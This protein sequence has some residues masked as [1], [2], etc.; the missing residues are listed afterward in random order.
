MAE[1]SGEGFIHK[2]YPDLQ[3]STSVAGAIRHE[4][5][6]IGVKI[7]NSPDKRLEIFL[8]TME[9]VFINDPN[10]PSSE[11]AEKTALRR[12]EI[13][14]KTFLY[15]AVL[16]DRD[17]VPD[18]YFVLQIK[19]AKERGQ[20]GDLELNGIGNVGDV[21]K[22]KRR[23]VGVVIYNDQKKSLDMWV[24]YLASPDSQYP[25]WFK[26]YTLQ[27]VLK[28]GT[29]DKSK[30]EFS[31]R[32]KETTTIFPDL[33]REALAYV[34]DSLSQYY[35]KDK[36]PESE[37]L[38]RVLKSANFGK[39]YTFS[40]ERTTPV[41][42]ENKK[43]TEGE[44]VKFDKGSD[45][46]ALYESLQGYGTGWCTAGEET[47]RSQLQNGDFYV[48]YTKDENGRN[49]IPRIAVRMESGQVAEVR[50]INDHQNLEE[51]MLDIARE[52]YKSLPGGDSFEKRDSDMKRVTLIDNKV[53]KGEELT[54]DELRFIYEIDRT[55]DGFG[56][57]KDPR[58]EEVILYRD[59][60]K[61][62]GLVFDCQQNQ[63]SLTEEETLR[64]D[65][66][67]HYG[68]LDFGDLTST[69]SLTLPKLVGGDLDLGGLTSVEGLTLPELIGGSLD[70]GGLTSV[71]GLTLPETVRGFINLGHL[72]S[73]EGL[74][75]PR[76]VG[77]LINLGPFITLVEKNVLMQRYPR[78]DIF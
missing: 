56:Y 22:E 43:R 53:K 65:I 13:F 7:P 3:K 50:G 54:V 12:R 62:L 76:S 28:M 66:K 37:E 68:S 58:I 18:S 9:R 64:G 67:Y 2:R 55:I 47:A 31:K 36:K 38:D 10:H 16:I 34:Y 6:L 59:K 5:G 72:T 27:S 44:W 46:T 33:N 1:M 42:K 35:L 45:P 77:G 29:Y 11:T 23:E 8:K 63:I 75:L 14:K 17:N 73:T 60:R 70:L 26:Y 20:G 39:I 74:I 57:Q 71:K 41:S 61:D 49:V 24:D 4:E 15:P 25:T 21:S 19:I 78:L 32:T 69:E 52:K 30:H 40:I 48:Y 51:N